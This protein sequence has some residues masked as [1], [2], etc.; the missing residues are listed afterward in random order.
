MSIS[1]LRSE[2]SLRNAYGA[3]LAETYGAPLAA[4]NVHVTSGCNQ[5]F[6]CAAMA[7]A[8]AGDAVLM[9]DPYYFNQETTLAML[10]IKTR[11]APCDKTCVC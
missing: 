1:G 3:H 4:G 2:D 6:I 8:G 5:A 11:F 9:S 10:G 7:I